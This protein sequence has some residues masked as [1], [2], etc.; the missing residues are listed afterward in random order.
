MTNF[1]KKIKELSKDINI[2][3]SYDKRVKETLQLIEQ[4]EDD[5]YNLPIKKAGKKRLLRVAVC[6][7]CIICLISVTALEVHADLFATFKENLLDFF[8]FSSKEEAKENG[9]DSESVYIEGKPDL[10]LELQEVMIGS[11]NI[12]LLV[13]IT[14]PS[15]IK[16]SDAVG[17]DYFCFCEGDNYNNDDLLSGARDCELLEVSAEKP[18]VATYVVSITYEQD[19]E[20]GCNVTAYFKDLEV[21][22][23]SDNPEMLVEG[24][25]SITF[26]LWKT[27]T[28][29][30]TIEGT[31]DMV[32]SYINTTATVEYIELTPSGMVLKTDISNFPYDELGVSDT[33]IAVKLKLIDGNEQII[34]SH[35]PEESFLQSGSTF[36]DDGDER[37]YQTDTLEFTDI[38]DIHMVYG[39]YI[40]DLYIPVE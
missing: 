26:P 23:Y 4:T 2:S 40:E 24:M 30:I 6:V 8:G 28:D 14:A 39:I 12:Y 25:W 31:S 29:N 15:N 3:A 19:L 38:I 13:K 9:V 16:F 34:V 10:M 17:F 33:T 22:P 1:D 27:V 36:Y 35:N 32:F 7:I 11:H 5:E 37:T 18:N 20:E 21:N